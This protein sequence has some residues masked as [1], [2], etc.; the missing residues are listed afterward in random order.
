MSMFNSES[1]FENKSREHERTREKREGFEM[2]AD[3]VKAAVMERADYIVKDV[4]STK[5]QMKNI[6][7]NMHAVKQ[8]IRQLR[9][10]L[11]L[12]DDDDS[13]SIQMDK[14][15]VDELRQKIASYSDELV[16]MRDELIREQKEELITNGFVGDV[17]EEAERLIEQMIKDVMKEADIV[18]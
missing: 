10:L 14:K 18:R 17:T 13:S 4:Q 8:Q 15:R 7:M 1:Q 11:Q 3:A 2:D 12:A 9:Q 6:V 16:S 5:K